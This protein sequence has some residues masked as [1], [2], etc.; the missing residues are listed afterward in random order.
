ML[1]FHNTAALDLHCSFDYPIEL[2]VPDTSGVLVAAFANSCS[3]R[4]TLRTL[5]PIIPTCMQVVS[6]KPADRQLVVRF[7]H[8]D[9]GGASGMRTYQVRDS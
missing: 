2:L 3:L 8:L 4:P 1:A 7:P 9:R 6:C 5:L